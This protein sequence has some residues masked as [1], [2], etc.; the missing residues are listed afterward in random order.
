MP[1]QLL[2]VVA[3]RGVGNNNA[4]PATKAAHPRTITV[5]CLRTGFTPQQFAQR[6]PDLDA[7]IRTE[8]YLPVILPSLAGKDLLRELDH[9]DTHCFYQADAKR[10]AEEWAD[11]M[12]DMAAYYAEGCNDDLPW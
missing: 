2:D 4:S 3:F 1:V 11:G 5:L 8:G 6:F 12:E 7:A 10:E 9:H